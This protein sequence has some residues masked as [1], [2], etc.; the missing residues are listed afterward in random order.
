MPGS[1]ENQ[2]QSDF[3]WRGPGFSAPESPWGQ[4]G[5]EIHVQT[6]PDALGQGRDF[7][8]LATEQTESTA[9]TVGRPA[10]I[11]LESQPDLRGVPALSEDRIFTVCRIQQPKP[12][13]QV[14]TTEGKRDHHCRD[15]VDPESSPRSPCCSQPLLPSH[16]ENTYPDTHSCHLGKEERVGGS[17]RANM[18]LKGLF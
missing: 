11:A 2:E 13:E 6:L 9:K 1:E 4:T 8:V 7:I 14:V 18:Y 15:S 10:G 16:W 3:W 12:G 17:L 5:C